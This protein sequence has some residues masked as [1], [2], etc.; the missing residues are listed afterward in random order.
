MPWALRMK[1]N[2]P[3]KVLWALFRRSIQD[4]KQENAWHL[5]YKLLVYW[6]YL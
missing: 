4:G 1:I 3:D 2:L 6:V 5:E